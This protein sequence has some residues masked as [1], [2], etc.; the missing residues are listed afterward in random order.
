[1][2]LGNGDRKSGTGAFIGYD[3]SDRFAQISFWMPGADKPETL[4]QV[5][6]EEQ[7]MIPAVLCR[8]TDRDVW[9]YGREA[10]KNAAAGDGILVENL[11]SKALAGESVEV[12]GESYEGAVLLSLFIK[13]SLSLLAGAVN[14]KKRACSFLRWKKWISR[15]WR[16]CPG[17]RR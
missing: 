15:P 17:W 12:D 14:R 3:I 6:G 10:L 8:R 11:L 4:T 16:C 2:F 1:M 5:M 9:T 13:R 7:Y